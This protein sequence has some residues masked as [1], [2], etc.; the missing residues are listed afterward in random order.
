MT[1]GSRQ[2]GPRSGILSG[3]SRRTRSRIVAPLLSLVLV[4]VVAPSAAGWANGGS[5]GNGYST[6]DWLVDQGLD[7]LTASG[8]TP[9][10][11]DRTAA[12]LRTDD[13]DTVEVAADASRT[14]EH[15]Y[16][17]TGKRGGAVHRIAELYSSAVAHHAKGEF[18]EAS[19]DIGLLAHFYGDILQPYHT[20]NDGSSYDAAHHA[21]ELAVDTK[22]RTPEASPGWADASQTVATLTDIRRTAIAAASYSRV[23][24]PD[25][26]AAWM[27]SKSVTDA[28]VSRI[29][30]EVLKRGGKDL[31]SIIWSIGQ[32]KGRSPAVASMSARVKWVGVRAGEPNQALYVTVKAAGGVG[33]E[34]VEVRVSWPLP[35][36]K[37]LSLR[38]WTGPTGEVKLVQGV[39]SELPL[40]VRRAVGASVTV[41]GVTTSRAPW[42]IPSPRLGDGTAGFKTVVNDTTPSA[43]QTVTVTSLARDTRGVGVPGLL[44]TWTWDYDGTIVTTSGITGS[45]GRATSSRLIRSTTTRAT[46]VITGRV[47]SYSI[48]R[49]ASASFRRQ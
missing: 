20:A 41:N 28:T 13:P 6:H 37:T 8:R 32:G 3:M 43:G 4:S 21:Y 27:R 5:G 44:V 38:T 15:V 35:G 7:V 45:T 42:F 36:D 48:N 47:Q 30:G 16:R 10:W 12:L 22:T 31:A 14:I 1:I 9:A 11:F 33:I 17:D 25:L 19:E 40:L 26:H 23:R 2:V 46:V 29:T 34:G 18:T 39:S 24:F 49:S